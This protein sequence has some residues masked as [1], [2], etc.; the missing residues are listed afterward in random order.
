MWWLTTGANDQ[1]IANQL[2]LRRSS[3]VT[4]CHMLR[5]RSG[6]HSRA[7][8]VAVWFRWHIAHGSTHATQ[9]PTDFSDHLAR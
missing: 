7:A 9:R 1:E 3:V 5:V 2:G 4:R 8:L 6:C